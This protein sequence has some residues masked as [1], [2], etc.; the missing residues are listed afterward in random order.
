MTTV[1]YL[2]E[3]KGL[4]D[5]SLVNSAKM[6]SLLEAMEAVEAVEQEGDVKVNSSMIELGKTE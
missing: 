5:L 3:K 2:F 6:V 1:D 4:I